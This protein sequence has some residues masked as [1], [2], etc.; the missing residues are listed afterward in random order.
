MALCRLILSASALVLMTAASAQAALVITLTE[1]QISGT[2]AIVATYSGSLNLTGATPSGNGTIGGSGPEYLMA[3]RPSVGELYLHPGQV[4]FYPV[5]P[6]QT[7]FGTGT[8]E[9]LYVRSPASVP[10]LRQYA[11]ANPAPSYALNGTDVAV[12][13]SYV[14]TTP[15]SG[16][17][18]FL[19]TTF[20]DWGVTPG[21]NTTYTINGTSETV[22]INVVPEPTALAA[23]ACGLGLA[24]VLASSRRKDRHS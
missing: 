24:G 22:S 19:T 18:Q 4:N 13:I 12:D 11:Y 1:Q 8:T 3:V 14:P 10:G 16:T 21:A 7:A 20:A 17:T 5:T 2:T 9:I 23:A 15:I 6:Q